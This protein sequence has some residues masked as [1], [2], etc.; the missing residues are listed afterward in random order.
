MGRGSKERK[1]YTSGVAFVSG[2]LQQPAVKKDEGND[3]EEMEGANEIS[4]SSR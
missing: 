4:D 1:S 2:G 3:E